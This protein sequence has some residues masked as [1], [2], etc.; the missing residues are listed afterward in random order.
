MEVLSFATTWDERWAWL[1]EPLSSVGQVVM[2]RACQHENIAQL[3]GVFQDLGPI[4]SLNGYIRVY[5]IILY[6]FKSQ[7][8]TRSKEISEWISK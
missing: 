4:T 3:F 6:E 8:Y 1:F 2:M 5:A 7:K